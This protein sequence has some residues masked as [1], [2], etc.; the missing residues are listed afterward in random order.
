MLSEFPNLK[1]NISLKNNLEDKLC[2]EHE[3]NIYYSCLCYRYNRRNPTSFKIKDNKPITYYKVIKEL[4][5]EN[6]NP[7]CDHISLEG[8]Y[9]N[10]KTNL[11]ISFI[12]YFFPFL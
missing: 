5:K 1:F 6:F 9:K 7:G 11:F 8:I 10:E 2:E 3:I 12:V 4:Y